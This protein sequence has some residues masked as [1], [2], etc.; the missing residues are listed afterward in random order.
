MKAVTGL[1]SACKIEHLESSR[2]HSSK[3]LASKH[4]IAF[5]WNTDHEVPLVLLLLMECGIS[6]SFLPQQGD[7]SQCRSQ[8]SI[9]A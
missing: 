3:L 1:Q 9:V 8:I 2:T 4:T 6:S 7:T 5:G